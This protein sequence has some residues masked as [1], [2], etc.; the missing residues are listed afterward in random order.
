MNTTY[1]ELCDFMGNAQIKKISSK[2]VT[3]VGLGGIG[4]ALSEILVRNNISLRIVDKE[5][6]KEE[7]VSRQSLYIA[8]DL[9]KFKAKQ[10]KKRLEE[11]NKEAKIKT[12]HED[13]V[14]DNIFLLESDLIIDT[15]NNMKTS[16]AIDAYTKEKNITI[17]FE[18]YSGAKGHL[19]M[20]K[21]K[22][23]RVKQIQDQLELE[24]L[25]KQGAFSPITT[26]LAS[27][28]AGETLKELANLEI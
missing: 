4:S 19:V 10:A 9:T 16:L 6:V 15:S 20:V 23:N 27:L 26:L 22:N 17:L 25:K 21:G 1:L 8:E 5:R 24:P 28:L 7:D 13:L 3:V 14:E 11:I 12:F 18:N 2:T